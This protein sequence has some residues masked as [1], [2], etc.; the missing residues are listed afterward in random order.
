MDDYLQYPRAYYLTGI[1]EQSKRAVKIRSTRQ[2]N[3]KKL[4]AS[5]VGFPIL[6][7][8]RTENEVGNKPN[9]ERQFKL[10]F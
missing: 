3:D 2:M 9:Q 7:R 6:C 5:A 10:P 8:L 1:M 4:Y